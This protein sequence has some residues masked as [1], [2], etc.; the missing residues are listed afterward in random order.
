MAR[1]PTRAASGFIARYGELVQV[2]LDAL[3]PDDLQELYQEA[4]DEFWDTSAYDHAVEQEQ[5][6]R[7]VLRS[8]RMDEA[9]ELIE[10]DDEDHEE[11]D[12]EEDEDD[13]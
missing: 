13:E 1:R 10:N 11:D 7:K 2:E 3:D 6:E 8:I 5:R 4:L 12:D 9:D